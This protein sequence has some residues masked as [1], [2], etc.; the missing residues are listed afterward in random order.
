MYADDNDGRVSG[1]VLAGANAVQ[2]A[3]GWVHGNAQMDTTDENLRKGDLWKY[4]GAAGV[5]R[6]PADRSKVK[7]RPDLLRFRSYAMEGS[8]NLKAGPETGVGIHP[9]ARAGGILLKDSQIYNPTLQFGFLDVSEASIDNGAFGIDD[10]NDNWRHG[11]FFW[12]H[13][14]GERH[15][16]G[17]NLSFLDGHVAPKRWRFTPRKYTGRAAAQNAADREDMMWLQE[18]M[19]LGQYRL[20]V[21]GLP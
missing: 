3:G 16:K 4:T 5:Y 20:R 21:L 11:P 13:H 7:N 15:G 12:I 19:H 14:P 10:E 9:D 8:I 1:N 6:C 18:R 2:N 17:A